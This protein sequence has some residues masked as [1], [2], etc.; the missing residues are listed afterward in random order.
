LDGQR[1]KCDCIEGKL[2]VDQG[3]IGSLYL[4]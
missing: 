1:K 4:I 2:P 3:H